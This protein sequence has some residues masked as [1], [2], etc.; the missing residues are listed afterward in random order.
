MRRVFLDKC[1]E[2]KRREKTLEKYGLEP[3]APIHLA[4][5]E[6]CA[7]STH[8]NPHLVVDGDLAESIK[9]SVFFFRD[10]VGLEPIGT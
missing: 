9:R 1:Q 6:H 3:A 7:L 10:F 5:R 2:A 8:P 4:D